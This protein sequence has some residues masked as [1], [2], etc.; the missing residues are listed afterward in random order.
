M[1]AIHIAKVRVGCEI[2]F[3]DTSEALSL[4][5]APPWVEE[6]SRDHGPVVACLLWLDEIQSRLDSFK[7]RI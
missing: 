6:N 2:V 3:T 1:K 7:A 5:S 4:P